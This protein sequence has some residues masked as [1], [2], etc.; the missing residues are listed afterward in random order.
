MTTVLV[1]V[2]IVCIGWSIFTRWATWP[3]PWERASTV[4]VSFLGL[5]VIFTT[6]PVSKIATAITGW[7]VL[8]AT[9]GADR[10]I[11][12][13]CLL[14]AA[15]AIAISAA[16]R[17]ADATHATLARWVATPLVA[18]CCL[19]VTSVVYG[20][21]LT[22]EQWQGWLTTYMAAFTIGLV[23][24]LGYAI[25]ALLVLAAD[26]RHRAMSAL[27]IIP[28]AA[29]VIAHAGQWVLRWAMPEGASAMWRLVILAC[30]VTWVAGFAL[31]AAY[32]WRQK[33]NGFQKLQQALR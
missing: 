17:I 23:Y 13:I 25:L 9:T 7:H 8:E 21:W 26:E 10:M 18:S 12:H 30:V 19:M 15:A 2:A 20:Q 28:C 6:I 14:F 1:L 3:C 31:A 33:I 11:G 22:P 27:Y 29:G 4:A 32:S 16:I 5:G 24:L